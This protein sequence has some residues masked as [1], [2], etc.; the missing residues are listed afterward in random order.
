M[1][2]IGIYIA[3][4]SVLVISTATKEKTDCDVR[5]LKSELLKELRPNFKYDSSHTNRFSLKSE[6]Q[7]K[8]IIIPLFSGEK[9]KL[10]FNTAALPSNF[11]I[12]IF[13]KPISAK[14]RKLLFSVKDS[15]DLDQHIFTFE[16]KKPQ[17]MYVNYILP[18]VQEENIYGCAVF[19]MGY[20]IN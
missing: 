10:L 4:I 20:K 15:E 18:G 5:I 2:K 3:L 17:T 14:N 16:P 6:E 11:E 9:Y 8:Q 19:L 13:D 12:Q 1:N 7:N